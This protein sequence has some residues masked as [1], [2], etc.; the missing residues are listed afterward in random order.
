MWIAVCNFF[1]VDLQYTATSAGHKN[2]SSGGEREKRM[3]P[4][5]DFKSSRCKECTCK[6]QTKTFFWPG[7][8]T[9]FCSETVAEYW[10]NHY[11]ICS[12]SVY[13]KWRFQLGGRLHKWSQ[14]QKET[15]VQMSAVYRPVAVLSIPAKVFES[16]IQHG[17]Q[18]QLSAQFLMRNTGFGRDVALSQIYLILWWRWS[19]QRMQVYWRMS[20]D[21][22][23]KRHL[24]VSIITYY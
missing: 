19:R 20:H 21:L 10:Q 9:R 24:T 14:Y 6:S 15:Q 17:M 11:I 13:H 23:T 18:R 12:M 5:R 16:A 8:C 3:L 2:S 22:T 1:R 4:F 7:R